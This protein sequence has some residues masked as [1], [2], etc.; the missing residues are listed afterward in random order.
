MLN[1]ETLEAAVI[2]VAKLQ[3][4]ALNSQE[5]LFVRTGVSTVLAAKKRHRKRM[6]A[7]SF[8]WKKPAPP[9]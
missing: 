2:C 1:R 9:R 3:G 8:H 6:N 5:L 4:Y 7:A